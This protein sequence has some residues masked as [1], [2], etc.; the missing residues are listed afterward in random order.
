MSKAPGFWVEPSRMATAS[1]FGPLESLGTKPIIFWP[2]RRAIRCSMPEKVP[3]QMNRMLSV[4][5]WM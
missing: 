4:V 1:I 3:P 2:S 5:T